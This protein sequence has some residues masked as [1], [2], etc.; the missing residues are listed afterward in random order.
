MAIIGSGD[1]A[2]ALNDREGFIFFAAGVS[3][4]C[5]LDELQYERERK[6]LLRDIEIAIKA[7]MHLVYFSSIA[8]FYSMTR[9]TV[10]KMEM[11]LLIQE[12][13]LNYTI[14]RIGNISWG[15]NPNTFI[16]FIR[17]KKSRGEYVVIR[18]EW[19]YMID[20]EALLFITDNLPKYGK[21]EI[22]IFGEMK[23]VKDLI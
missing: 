7:D 3:N 22:S 16:N 11:E 4:S 1:I 6:R 21:H 15:T 9:Y 20:K 5:E 14:I 2:K 17:N 12:R 10:H 18:D 13:C 8:C 23:K 19:K